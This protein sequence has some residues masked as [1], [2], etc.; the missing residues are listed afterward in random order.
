VFSGVGGWLKTFARCSTFRGGV[1]ETRERG[2]DAQGAPA[3]D[4]A[5]QKLD[6][7]T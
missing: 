5:L 3:L 7:A 1:S 2:E 4:A 6:W